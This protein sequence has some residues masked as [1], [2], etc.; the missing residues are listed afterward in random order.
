MELT[1]HHKITET[2]RLCLEV[3]KIFEDHPDETV[4]K[5]LG[6]LVA[7]WMDHNDGQATLYEIENLA[8][9]LCNSD[10]HTQRRFH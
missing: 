2:E 6:M 7:F 1:T 5:C 8:Q 10:D 3:A 4:T 9:N